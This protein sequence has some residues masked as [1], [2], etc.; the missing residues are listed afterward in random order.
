MPEGVVLSRVFSPAATWSKP[1]KPSFAFP[2]LSLHKEVS[3]SQEETTR[4]G[5]QSVQGYRDR[6]CGHLFPLLSLATAIK[7]VVY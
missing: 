7:G 3:A 1:P 2:L 4:Q 6:N 5:G